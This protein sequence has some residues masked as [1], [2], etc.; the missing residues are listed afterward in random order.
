MLP[1]CFQFETGLSVRHHHCYLFTTAAASIIGDGGALGRATPRYHRHQYYRYHWC[2]LRQKPSKHRIVVCC[3]TRNDLQHIPMFH[4]LT[5]IIKPENIHAGIVVIA[6]PVLMAMQDHEIAL[7]DCAFERY[8]FSRILAG[9]ALEVV[10]K[11]L[12]TIG[13]MGIVLGIVGTG[14]PVYGGAG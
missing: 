1:L 13:D 7:G 5:V 12:F 11:R 2:G 9:H 14:I 8:A 6:G 4:D 10:D 3:V